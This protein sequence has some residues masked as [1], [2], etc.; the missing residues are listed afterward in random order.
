MLDS[1]FAV[2]IVPRAF[3]RNFPLGRGIGPPVAVPM[4][5]MTSS[6]P[7]ALTMRLTSALSRLSTSSVN[8][9]TRALSGVVLRIVSASKKAAVALLPMLGMISGLS[10]G[11]SAAIVFAS[12]VS[13]LT[14][15][16]SPE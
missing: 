13:G 7:L 3:L 8:Q 16:A 14:R 11:T 15:C 2:A 5:M 9:T 6:A 10:E 12:S 1:S 4:P